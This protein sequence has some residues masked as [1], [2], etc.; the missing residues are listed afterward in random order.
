MSNM[1][2]L[3][4]YPNMYNLVNMN[5]AIDI[6]F[7]RRLR[8]ARIASG[9]T[10]QSAADAFG[11]SLRGYCRWEKGEREP[12]FSA[13]VSIAETLNVSIDHLLGLAGEAP[14]GGR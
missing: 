2:I 3:I 8:E 6:A 1:Y 7:G 4:P 12:N 5:E 9:L 10:Q 11:I 13:L 14:A